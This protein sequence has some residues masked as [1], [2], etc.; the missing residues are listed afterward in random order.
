[1]IGG[2]GTVTQFGGPG[3]KEDSG[4]TASGHST[5]QHPD[6]PYCALPIPVVKRY[7]LK[8]GAPIIFQHGEV[9]VTAILWDL[10]PSTYLRRVGDVAP[11]VMRALGGSGLLTGVRVTFKAVKP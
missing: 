2:Y 3:D 4:N 8:W 9:K 10:G 5:K 7:G 1:M 11:N 6:V